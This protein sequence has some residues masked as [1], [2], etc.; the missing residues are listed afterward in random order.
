MNTSNLIT[1]EQARE[2]LN[3]CVHGVKRPP[4]GKLRYAY[5][6]PG[7]PYSEQWDW[8][9]FFMGVALTAENPAEAIYLKNW[10]LN[11]IENAAPDGKVAGCLTAEGWDPRLNHIKPFLAQGAYLASKAL[12]DFSW[13]APVW[14]TLLRVATY[15]FRHLWFDS[16][17]LGAWLD[18]ME[19][20]AD[21]NVA[22][23]EYP[24]GSVLA[25][26]L[27]TFLF[28]ECTALG[29]IAGQLG[30]HQQSRELTAKAE[31]IREAMIRHLWSDE[32]GIF[33]NLFTASG[34][35]VKRITYSSFVPLWAGVAPEALG[36]ESIERY[37]LNPEHLASAWGFR[38]LSKQ[39]PVYNNIN[40]IKP[41][42][43]WQGPIWPIANYIY[44]HAL[45]RYGFHNEAA[46]IAQT[47]TRLVLA[48]IERAG[49]MQENYDAVTGLP[50]A[51]PNFISWNILVRNMIEEAK[52][53]C[54]PFGLP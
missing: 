44:M 37:L 2:K 5:L 51:A 38:T 3:Y 48:D 35:P 23:L 34:K 46:A 29:L 36:R 14:D 18:S 1:S 24:H 49:G 41:H 39:D 45:I 16:Y 7:G 4:S 11:F 52:T 27:N 43:N 12:D 21:N 32:A 9:A 22:A 6:V 19:S 20:G 8:D 17:G 10:T 53:H 31:A 42:S 47:T 25:A 40:M 13:L 28:R 30:K 50:L 15:R 33:L 54:D 26:D